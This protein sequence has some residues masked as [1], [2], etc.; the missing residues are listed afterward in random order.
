[1]PCL[2]FLVFVTWVSGPLAVKRLH[3]RNKSW[4]WPLITMVPAVLLLRTGMAHGLQAL[5]AFASSPRHV[6]VQIA[7]WGWYVI[8]LGFMKG[9]PGRNM[10]GPAPMEQASSAL[11]SMRCWPVRAIT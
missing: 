6:T 10:Y 9:T 1:M 2:G 3:D 5:L 8:E 7:L 11:N 4:V